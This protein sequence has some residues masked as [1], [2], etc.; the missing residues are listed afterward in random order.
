MGGFRVINVFPKK[1]SSLFDQSVSCDDVRLK[2]LVNLRHD[3]ADV[4]IH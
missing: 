1:G 2:G 3:A 4:D